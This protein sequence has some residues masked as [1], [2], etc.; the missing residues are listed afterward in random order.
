[1]RSY[2]N[3]PEVEGR[4]CLLPAH[5]TAADKIDLT[6]AESLRAA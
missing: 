3:L 5:A 1:M 4:T 6:D 2:R